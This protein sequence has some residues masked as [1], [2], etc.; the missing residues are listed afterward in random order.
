MRRTICGLV[1]L[2]AG[3]TARAGDE[4]EREPINYT[5]AVPD[6]PVSRLQQRIDAGKVK[7]SFDG[8]YGYLKQLLDELNVPTSSQALVFSKTSLQRHRI[9][10]KTPR[11]LYFNDDVYVGHCRNGAVLELSVA[12][13][14]LGAVFY[15]LD[16]QPSDRPKLV[17]Q[18]D[19]CLLCHG[20]SQTRGIPGHL[21]RSVFPDKSGHPILA[22]GTYRIDQTSPINKRWGGWY[23]TGTHGKQ[24]HLGNLLLSEAREPEQVDN[25]GGLN[26]T[27]LTDRFDTSHYLTPHSDLVALMV[28]EHQAEMHNHLTR[29]NFQ[30]RL[31]LH[32]AAALNKELGRPADYQSESTARRIRSACDPLVKYLLFAGEAKL[33]DKMQGTTPFAAEFA[34]RSPRDAKGRSLRDFDLETRLFKYPCSYLIYSPS[35]DALPAAAK[36]YVLQQLYDTLTGRP[37][38]RD[39]DHLTAEDC[40]AILEILRATKPD[41]PAYWHAAGR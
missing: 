6:N 9:G 30:T 17:R 29:A 33:T 28:L 31:A 13:P 8:E 35:F 38:T 32:E 27:D 1:L 34:Q 7:L 37:Y 26:V 2:L 22:S 23:V 5:K 14:Q 19:S 12:D 15:T 20:S 16:Q 4:F 41:L 18:G 24:P 10:P 3:A 21:I 25:L 11:A 40:Q 36:D 39:F